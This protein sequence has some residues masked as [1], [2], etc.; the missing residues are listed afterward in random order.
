M[1]AALNNTIKYSST[2]HA[3]TQALYGF[4]THETFD[5]TSLRLE[6]LDDSAAAAPEATPPRSTSAPAP[7]TGRSIYCNCVVGDST[8]NENT[9]S[10]AE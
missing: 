8:L 5:P 2:A 6:D 10:E 3:T 1:S 9:R 7:A 4:R